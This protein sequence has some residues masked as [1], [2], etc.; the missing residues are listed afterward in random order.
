MKNQR[1]FRKELQ[2]LVNDTDKILL[3]LKKNIHLAMLKM[4]IKF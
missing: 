2:G 1:K 4:L 3:A